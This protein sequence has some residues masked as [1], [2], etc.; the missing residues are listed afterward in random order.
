MVSYSP[1]LIT[2]TVLHIIELA[3]DRQTQ[4]L[5]TDGLFHCKNLHGCL[6]KNGLLEIKI[7]VYLLA[8]LRASYTWYVGI[9]EMSVESVC[10]FFFYL[11]AR[12]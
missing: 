12:Q 8:S 3:L 2:F 7:F 1:S 10:C 6:P 4:F 5:V 9:Q 11:P